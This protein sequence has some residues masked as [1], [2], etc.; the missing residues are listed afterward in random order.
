[1]PSPKADSNRR[2]SARISILVADDH[3][4]VRDG[5]RCILERR[6]GVCVVAAVGDGYAAIREAERLKPDVVVM[7]ISMPGMNGID[8]TRI[9]S[10]KMPEVAVIIFSMHASPIDV[11]RALEAGA[12]GYISKD[13]VTEELVRAVRVVAD[14]KRYIGQGLTQN[15]LDLQKGARN[16]DYT[17]EVLT[18][19]ER[20]ILKLVAEGKSNPEIAVTIGLSPRTVETYRLRLMRKLGIENLPS[21]VRYAIRHG[22]TPLE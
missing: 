10:D 22:I 6:L 3:P 1:M 16:G 13:A 12:R 18:A 21:L 15:L 2:D 17:V 11:R 9:I 4:V 7:D 5:V 8:A 20:N 19:T 14:G